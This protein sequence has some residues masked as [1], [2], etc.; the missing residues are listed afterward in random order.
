M[1]AIAIRFAAQ[2]TPHAVAL[3]KSKPGPRYAE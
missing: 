1:N 2:P 3:L